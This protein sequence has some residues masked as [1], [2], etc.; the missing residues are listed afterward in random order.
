VSQ[1]AT[2]TPTPAKAGKKENIFTHKFGPLPMWAWVAI[3]AVILIGYFYWKN[4]QSASTTGTPTGASQVP[5]FVNQ[6][7]T[8]VVP[9][10]SPGEDKDK[11]RKD[12]DLAPWKDESKKDKKIRSWEHKHPGQEYPFNSWQGEPSAAELSAY[13]ANPEFQPS[14][15]QSSEMPAQA[16]GPMVAPLPRMGGTPPVR[17]KARRG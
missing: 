6:V 9:P 16:A 10:T 7:Y 14:M 15:T 11:G 2:E 17:G 4:K 12:V 8:S 1:M 3:A 5:Q 13:N